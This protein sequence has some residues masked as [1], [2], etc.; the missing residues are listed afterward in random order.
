MS[1]LPQPGGDN[2]N[3]GSILNDYLSQA[4][5]NDG[6]L[7]PSSVSTAAI[8]NNSIPESKLDQDVRDKLNTLAGQQ[9]ATGAQGPTGPTGAT[10]P[11]GPS[12]ASGTPGAQGPS[13]VSGSQGATGLQGPAGASGP[14]GATGPSGTPSTV[15]G[16]VGATGA[17]GATGPTGPTG[18]SGPS[19]AASTVPGPTGATGTQGA[20]GAQGTIGATGATG[21]QGPTGP[22]GSGT[23]VATEVLFS[24]LAGAGDD[25]KLAAFMTAQSGGSFKGCTLV[26]DEM[27]DYTF[28]AQQTLYNG[29][30]IRGPF[31]PQDQARGSMPIGNRIRLRMTGGA[32]GWFKQPAGNIFGV[33]ITNMSIDG[34]ANSYLVEGNASG[35]LWTSVF[36]D[37][38]VQNALGV[39][40]S[41]SQSVLVTACTIDG[42]WNVNNVQS[43]AFA[44]GGS[45]FYFNPSM[46]LLDSPPELLAATGYLMN[47]SSLSNTWVSNIYC[48]AE[49]HTAALLTGGSSDESVWIKQCVF[50]GRNAGQP[51][52]GSLIRMTGGQFVLR[53]N[54][55]AFA[56]TNPGATGR[57][58]A[59]VIH[60]QGGKLLVDGATYRRATGVA[61]SV[62]FIYVTG[63]STRVVVRNVV[64]QGSWTG[65]PIVQQSQAGLIDA[66]DSVTVVTA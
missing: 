6:T 35:V 22:A 40:G 14:T 63:A 26:L 49:G 20:S 11:Q 53:D 27:R 10:G 13:G 62:P 52:P 37:I 64:A 47:L 3:W 44:L 23:G 50:E 8:Q 31:R 41:P 48:T 66:D 57:S 15:P 4:H 18:P 2:G 25:A 21:P 56:M 29:F 32:K 1:R 17:T 42:W 28:T 58:D 45:D 65:K 33:S 60:V 59:G 24:T 54:R 43:R 19:G 34:D 30:S 16:P 61:E 51:S 38:S 7:K 55:F 36:R 46:M 5:N 9:G 39:L 12:G